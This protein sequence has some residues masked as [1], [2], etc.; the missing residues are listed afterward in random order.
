[1]RRALSLKVFLVVNAFLLVTLCSCEKRG[2]NYI[3]RAYK[4]KELDKILHVGM[5][6]KDVIGAFGEPSGKD[7]TTYLYMIDPNIKT[8]PGEFYNG[9]F[10]V[11]FDDNGKVIRWS[12]LMSRNLYYKNASAPVNTQNSSNS[13]ERK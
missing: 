1:M 10:S 4:K 7:S 13:N 8:K 5:S 12:I 2:E 3:P 9:G 6:S 11:D